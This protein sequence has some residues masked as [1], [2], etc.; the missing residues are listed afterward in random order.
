M[1]T[2]PLLWCSD[3]SIASLGF[4]YLL[5]TGILFGLK[6]PVI[7]FPFSLITSISYSSILQRTFN[8]TITT[9]MVPRTLSSEP[10]RPGQEASWDYEFSM[11]DQGD[12]SGVD[13]Y[14]K[15]HGLNDASLAASRRAQIYN[16][17]SKPQAKTA[18]DVN[19][20]EADNVDDGEGEGE[21]AKAERELQ[22]AEDE[23]EEDFDPEDGDG[24]SDGSGTDSENEGMEHESGDDVRHDEDEDEGACD[25]D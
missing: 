15:G 23:E 8:L 5:S 25:D 11:I 10:L 3:A 6:K 21:L 24:D 13:A 20:S 18:N 17:N 2:N 7:Y 9:C 19:G 1:S 22:D 12:F 14:V 16:V 4:L